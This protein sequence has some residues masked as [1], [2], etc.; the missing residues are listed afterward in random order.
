MADSGGCPGVE[1][2]V[3]LQRDGEHLGHCLLTYSGGGAA[4]LNSAAAMHGVPA[5][6]PALRVTLT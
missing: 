4:W 5:F 2:W 1:V 6:A 3:V